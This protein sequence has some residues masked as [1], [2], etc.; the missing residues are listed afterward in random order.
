MLELALLAN[1]INALEAERVGLVNMVLPSADWDR[2]VEETCA[3]LARSF[4]CSTA[5]G[6]RTFYRQAATTDMRE[7]YALATDTMVGMFGSPPYQA[8]MKAFLSRRKPKP[9]GA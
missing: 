7:K 9:A 8:S 5:D 6:K 2:R 1:E 4:N 3:Q